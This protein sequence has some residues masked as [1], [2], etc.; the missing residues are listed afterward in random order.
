MHDILVRVIL[1]LSLEG[2]AEVIHML[3]KPDQIYLHV[4]TRDVQHDDLGVRAGWPLPHD[5]PD[6]IAELL[7]SRAECSRRT[8]SQR[9]RARAR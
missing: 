3:G 1:A 6:Q 4:V 9:P 7:P 8:R 5:F 2:A